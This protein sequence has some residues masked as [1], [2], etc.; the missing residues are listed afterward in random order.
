MHFSSRKTLQKNWKRKNI[1]VTVVLFLIYTFFWC[2]FSPFATSL[3]KDF[4]VQHLYQFTSPIT[5]QLSKKVHTW[6]HFHSVLC[7]C[8][9]LTNLQP[10][11]WRSSC[12]SI[13][14]LRG[15]MFFSS[16]SFLLGRFRSLRFRVSRRRILIVKE[17]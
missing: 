14:E 7:V 1:T 11:C 15:R 16:N 17:P 9:Y 10:I 6:Q 8:V 13:S 2:Y 3:S 12:L 5:L 4:I